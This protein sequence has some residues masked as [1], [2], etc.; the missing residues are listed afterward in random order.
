[1]TACGATPGGMEPN[2]QSMQPS[3]CF[4]CDEQACRPQVSACLADSKC[5]AYLQCVSHCRFT[6]TGDPDPTCVAGCPSLQGASQALAKAFDDCRS[7]PATIA[8][9]PVCN[10]PPPPLPSIL[11]QQCPPAANVSAC[12]KCTMER[13]CQTWLECGSDLDCQAAMDC[14]DDCVQDPNYDA[15]LYQCLR[16]N[17][18]GLA[19]YAQNLFC[20]EYYCTGASCVYQ[21][22]PPCLNCRNAKCTAQVAIC[23]S[24]PDCYLIQQCVIAAKCKT[25]ECYA[26]CVALHPNGDAQF[27]ELGD[28]LEK[29]CTGSCL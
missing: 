27:L 18:V 23:Y 25:P 2:N 16:L 19:L 21:R 11:T 13:C 28:C 26:S 10:K 29:N 7:L 8:A 14:H 20:V 12:Y 6:S 1:M 24:N 4:T 5:A 17:K 22:P 9:C 15:C 3:A